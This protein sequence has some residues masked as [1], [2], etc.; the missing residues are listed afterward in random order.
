MFTDINESKNYQVLRK[1]LQRLFSCY[2]SIDGQ[3]QTD[4]MKLR[5]AAL[6]FI[7]QAVLQVI[8]NLV[9]YLS[10]VL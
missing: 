10:A 8:A 1:L 5:Y 6:N 4:L 3:I 7:I 2:L 9:N